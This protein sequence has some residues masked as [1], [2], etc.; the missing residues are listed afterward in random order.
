MAGCIEK[1]MMSVTM[2]MAL[3][4]A[5]F[6][7]A[8][9]ETVSGG[10]TIAEASSRTRVASVATA[11]PGAV[12]PTTTK[13]AFG[14]YDPSHGYADTANIDIEHVF[15][16][17]RTP[18]KT[19]LDT[20]IAYAAKRNRQFMITVEPFTMADDWVS[21]GDHLFADVVMGKF[22]PQ[23]DL[24]CK[25]V[26]LAPGRP[27]VRWGQEMEDPT[28]R[29]PWAR[30]DAAGFIR[31]YRHFVTRCRA[32]APNALFVWSPKGQSNLANYYP[33]SAWVDRVG[34]AIWG[35]EPADV[36]WYG[37]TRDFYQAASEKY[38]RVTRFGKPVMFAE[39][40]FAG[41]QTY[42]AGWK[43][44][45]L[46]TLAS[47]RSYSLLTAIVLF[48]D[49]EPWPWPSNLGLPDWRVGTAETIRNVIVNRV[50]S[51]D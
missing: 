31:A 6:G 3:G 23:T 13:V 47:S 34:V 28:G 42:R 10:N 1:L 22:D 21:G 32:S 15:M 7:T 16:A 33:G 43:T 17:W 14:V 35:Y 24:I 12:A 46:A 41:G 48:G 2:A 4:M 9:A 30:T 40:G 51:S 25:R 38:A 18:S 37:R 26:A 19:W 39:L 36:L 5:S 20:A 50:A 49:K 11:S 8:R 44:E 45:L 29:Y 27:L